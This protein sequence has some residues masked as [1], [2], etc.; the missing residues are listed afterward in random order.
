MVRPYLHIF[1]QIKKRARESNRTKTP[2][3]AQANV[4][5][6]ANPDDSSDDSEDAHSFAGRSEVGDQVRRE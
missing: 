1:A 3:T 4:N 5:A 6:G 2:K